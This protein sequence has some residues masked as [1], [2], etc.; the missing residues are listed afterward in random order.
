M[1]FDA[2]VIFVHHANREVDRLL[3]EVYDEAVAIEIALFVLVHLDTLVAV[4]AL[5]DDAVLLELILDFCFIC[6]AWKVADINCAVF[7]DFGFL[8]G[9]V[10]GVRKPYD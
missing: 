4:G 2:K 8:V 6:V 10:Y 1:V 7:L 9:L 3:L 5:V